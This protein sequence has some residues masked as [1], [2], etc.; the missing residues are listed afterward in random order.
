MDA[1]IQTKKIMRNA[2]MTYARKEGNH[3]TETQIKIFTTDEE[4]SP[5]YAILNNFV[6]VREITLKELMLVPKVDFLGKGMMADA[7]V[8]P[9]IK[10]IIKR[11]GGEYGKEVKSVS[12]IV[13]TSDQECNELKLIMCV[14]NQPFKRLRFSDILD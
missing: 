9:M 2:M 1:E 8:Q 5:R 13:A 7:L 4:G 11:L 3:V 14:D 6:D 10:N 12:V